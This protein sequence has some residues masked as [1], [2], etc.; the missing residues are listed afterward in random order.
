MHIIFIG[1]VGQCRQ[2]K[3]PYKTVKFR[4]VRENLKFRQFSQNYADNSAKDSSANNSDRCSRANMLRSLE[5]VIAATP[6][7]VIKPRNNSNSDFFSVES[8]VL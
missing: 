5:H 3:V 4:T 8:S 7:G 1:S 2:K 6:T